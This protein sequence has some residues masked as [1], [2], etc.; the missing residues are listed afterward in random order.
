MKFLPEF[1]VVYCECVNE[2][3][4]GYV[5]RSDDLQITGVFQQHFYPN[6]AQHQAAPANREEGANARLPQMDTEKASMARLTAI[7]KSSKNP[8]MY[9]PMHF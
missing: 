2:C 4:C 3:I 6:Q 1:G 7:N 8:T 9:S 5:R